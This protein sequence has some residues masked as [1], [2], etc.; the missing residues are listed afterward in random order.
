MSLVI[1][2]P[3]S[4]TNN[5]DK[6]RVADYEGWLAYVNGATTVY[7]FAEYET[8]EAAQEAVERGRL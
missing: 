2:Q 5:S 1:Q 3:N 8:Y 4:Q 6:Y 7:A